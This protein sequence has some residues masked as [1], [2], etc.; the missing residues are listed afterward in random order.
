MTGSTRRPKTHSAKQRGAATIGDIAA[1]AGVSKMTVSR[2]LSSPWSVRPDTRERIMQLVADLHYVP[3]RSA[4]MLSGAELLRL[5][6]LYNSPRS[7]YI[8]D[9]LMGAIDQASIMDIQLLSRPVELEVDAL[10]VLKGMVASGV[11]GII[12]TPPLSDV[13]ALL[14]V[15]RAAAMPVLLV[16]ADHPE[17][18]LSSISIDEG[19]AAR[20]ITQHLIAR[21]HRRI[22]FIMGEPVLAASHTR[23][24]G[25]RAAM[26]EAGLTVEPDLIAQGYFTYRS[27]L[28]A[29]EQL[30]DRDD[31]PTAIFAS[32]DD[33]AAA[34]VMV[35]H[36]RGLDVPDRLT[37]CGF[38][39][40]WIATNIYPEL[41]TIR[42]PIRDMAVDSIVLMAE[43]VRTARQGKPFVRRQV[44]DHALIVRQSVG[45]P[46]EAVPAGR[47]DA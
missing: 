27:G 1:A 26:S 36:R 10:G 4:R 31:P 24:E 16:G 44:A 12:L 25:F 41:T 34:T 15:A 32:N 43:A 30:L 28:V 7:S 40:S 29:A 6:L 19:A 14:A 46:N 47:E 39:D 38:D 20:E 35:A 23:L 13:D 22:G 2:V 18:M 3:N 21:G 8:V 45:A 33:M 17:D 37:V 42:Q 5:G 11:D 9:F